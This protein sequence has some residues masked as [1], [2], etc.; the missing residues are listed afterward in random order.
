MSYGTWEDINSNIY[1]DITVQGFNEPRGI[2]MYVYRMYV[3]EYMK[4]MLPYV[5]QTSKICC[6]KHGKSSA[7]SSQYL[8]TF[9][10]LSTRKGNAKK[11][12]KRS[13]RGGKIAFLCAASKWKIVKNFSMLK[14]FRMLHCAAINLSWKIAKE[15]FIYCIQLWEA[16]SCCCYCCC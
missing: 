1:H 3:C 11:T 9:Q 2:H 5:W 8:E 6:C 14:K 7:T 15:N 4:H 16:S 12:D 10:V 13:T